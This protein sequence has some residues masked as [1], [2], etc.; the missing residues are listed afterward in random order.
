MIHYPSL[1]SCPPMGLCS[2]SHHMAGVESISQLLDPGLALPLDQQKVLEV[3]VC[4]VQA[5]AYHV[6]WDLADTI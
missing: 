3:M 2:S 1:Y 5:E 6:F 4:L